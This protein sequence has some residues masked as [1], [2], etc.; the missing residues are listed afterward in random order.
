MSFRKIVSSHDAFEFAGKIVAFIPRS[1]Y[2]GKNNSYTTQQIMCPEMEA[3]VPIAFA[4][5]HSTICQYTNG[6]R[7]LDMDMFLK[8][9]SVPGT[10]TLTEKALK[11]YG[12]GYLFMRKASVDEIN[13]LK[14]L[15][16]KD[17]IKLAYNFDKQEI[18]DDL[19]KAIE[20]IDEVEQ[21]YCVQYNK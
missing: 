12:Q 8:P 14:N 18:I 6:D 5:V 21:L 9:D 15:I 10:T 19:N 11:N 13:M 2:Y 16:V 7:G 4:K 1:P 3:T 20:R 17:E